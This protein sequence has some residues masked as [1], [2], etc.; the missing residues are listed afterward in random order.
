MKVEEIELEYKDDLQALINRPWLLRAEDWRDVVVI[1]F[2]LS[3]IKELEEGIK[4]IPTH[5]YGEALREGC[6]ANGAWDC[7]TEALG[8][9]QKKLLEGGTNGKN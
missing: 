9:H 6:D 1:A 7:F 2:L 3:R 8:E 4:N 5:E